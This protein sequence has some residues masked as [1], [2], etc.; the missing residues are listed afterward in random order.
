MKA[1]EVID[2]FVNDLWV[3]VL[4]YVLQSHLEVLV[5]MIRCLIME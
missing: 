1:R 2:V 3:E 4:C 5:T